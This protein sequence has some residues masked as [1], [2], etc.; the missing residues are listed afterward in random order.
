VNQRWPTKTEITYTIAYI[1]ASKHDSNKI[2]TT[3]PI[4][5][6]SYK[7]ITYIA[8]TAYRVDL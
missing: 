7:T 6:G 5:S 3:I 2:P 4:F 1:L 8:E